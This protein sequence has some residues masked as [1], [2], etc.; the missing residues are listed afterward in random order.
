MKIKTISETKETPIVPEIKLQCP[1]CKAE[2]S[3]EAM[4]RIYRAYMVLTRF[5]REKSYRATCYKCGKITHVRIPPLHP[6][7]Y[8]CRKCKFEEEQE[9]RV[10]YKENPLAKKR[11]V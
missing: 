11:L 4:H 2:Y 3:I 9:I 5:N 8:L 10:G 7:Q 1:N 6:T